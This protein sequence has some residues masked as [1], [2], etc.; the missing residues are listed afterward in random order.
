[1]NIEDRLFA[2]DL[3]FD[4]GL[5]FFGGDGIADFEQAAQASR[6]GAPLFAVVAA[7]AADGADGDAI[8]SPGARGEGQA[9]HRPQY[10]GIARFAPD[11]A[12]D[13]SI[14]IGRHERGDSRVVTGQAKGEVVLQLLLA[15]QVGPQNVLPIGENAQEA[16][17]RVTEFD[18]AAAFGGGQLRFKEWGSAANLRDQRFRADPLTPRVAGW[19][20]RRGGQPTSMTRRF[21]TCPKFV[22]ALAL[23][24][25]SIFES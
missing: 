13:F 1:M 19:F 6:N 5:R 11:D 14:D 10:I 12:A 4:G 20:D 15:V 18:E 21:P 2:V 7:N 22:A 9:Q 16:V 17:G 8:F 23:Q 25:W 24:K 3:G